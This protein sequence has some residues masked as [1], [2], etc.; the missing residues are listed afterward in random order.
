MNKQQLIEF[1]QLVAPEDI[2]VSGI[3][4]EFFASHPAIETA[5]AHF[6]RACDSDM[7]AGASVRSFGLVPSTCECEIEVRA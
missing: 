1:I 3:K 7:L 5:Q 4:L 2:A 6:R